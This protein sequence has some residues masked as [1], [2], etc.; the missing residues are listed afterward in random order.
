MAAQEQPMMVDCQQMEKHAECQKH[1]GQTAADENCCSDHCD[2]TFG[3]QLCLSSDITYDFPSAQ[4]FTTHIPSAVPDPLIF[5][6][7]RPPLTIS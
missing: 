2:A 4:V 5:S 3:A 7:L 1:I 6:F